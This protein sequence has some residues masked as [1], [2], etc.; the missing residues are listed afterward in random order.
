MGNPPAC[1]AFQ[2]EGKTSMNREEF[3]CYLLAHF[4]AQ[5]D[6]P[7][8]RTPE[9]AVFRHEQNRKWFAIVMR[10]ARGKLGL[11]GEGMLDIV[12]LKC[13]PLL[14]GSL[15]QEPGFFPAYHMNKAYWITAALDG[16]VPDDQLRML[17]QMS[18]DA[19]APKLPKRRRTSEQEN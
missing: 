7:W 1:L 4:Q 9:F 15:R 8:E 17:A 11:P 3:E 16:S 19:T 12:N 18:F 5:R 13:D 2:E 10:I 14:L 6:Y